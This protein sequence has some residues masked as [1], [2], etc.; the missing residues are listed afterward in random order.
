MPQDAVEAK[1][2]INSKRF[3]HVHKEQVWWTHGSKGLLL[4]T[5]HNSLYA[6]SRPGTPYAADC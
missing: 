3:K 1:L 6:I 2:E 5:K 4:S